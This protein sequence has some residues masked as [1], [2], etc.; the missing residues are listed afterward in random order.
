MAS[1]KALLGAVA[2]RFLFRHGVVSRVT[3]LGPHFRR[4]DVEGR[5][6]EGAPFVAGDKVQ[7][8]LP[9]E[10]MRTYTPITWD[11]AR[12]SFVGFVHGSGGPGARWLTGVKAGDEVA[13]FGPRRSIDVSAERGPLVVVGD[14]T[15]LGLTAALTRAKPER[16][17]TAV[18]E[19]GFPDEL[20]EVAGALELRGV[21]AVPRGELEAAVRTGL[22]AG[23]TPVFTGRAASLQRLKRALGNPAGQTKAYW[24]EGK[25]G[26]D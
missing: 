9:G 15:S 4:V 16:Q 3:S 19:T 23:A 11:G 26:L 21:S 13:L 14:E 20:R 5:E 24:A 6:L 25:R 12:T 2:G 22:A 7:L 17:V 1:A 18:L 10:G 8:F